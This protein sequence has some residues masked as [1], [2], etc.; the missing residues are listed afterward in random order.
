MA[1]PDRPNFTVIERLAW[2]VISVSMIVM[3]LHF[4]WNYL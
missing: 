2:G 4:P 3:L 1:Q